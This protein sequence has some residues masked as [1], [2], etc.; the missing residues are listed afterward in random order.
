MKVCFLNFEGVPTI[1]RAIDRMTGGLNTILYNLA[2][3]IPH[4]PGGHEVSV[5]CRDDGS[6]SFA[7]RGVEMIAVPAGLRKPLSRK[8]AEAVL[9]EFT[10]GLPRVIKALR[11]DVIHTS[12][13]EA[14][15]AMAILRRDGLTT[16][17]VHT[18][19]ATLAVRRVVVE[20]M[21]PEEALSDT[22]GQRELTCVSCCDKVI[23]LCTQD[24]DEL[25]SV[26]GIPKEKIAVVPPGIDTEIFKLPEKKTG[27]RQKMII[28]SGRMSASKD[29]PFLLRSFR[30]VLDSSPD[31]NLVIVGGNS[32]ER[33]DLGLPALA[34]RLGIADRVSFIDGLPQWELAGMFQ[35]AR[36]FAGTSLHETFGLLVHEAKA[37]GTPF[38][39]RANSGYLSTSR[40]G[41]GGY[42]ADNLSEVGMAYWL[43][44]VLD[45]PEWAWSSLSSQAHKDAQRYDWEVS[46]AGCIEVYRGL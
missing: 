36:V 41:V 5:M 24:R 37:C 31:T 27:S 29:F 43:R 8:E 3:R 21:S 19:Y 34:G 26:F 6:T 18:N 23:A 28:G 11:P 22:I 45:S 2:T 9:Q 30:I 25:A 33:N 16:P 32:V 13:S 44:Y 14:G 46:C 1:E 42:F 17:W 39:A 4:L 40:N 10:S 7:G 35:K 15:L 20:G 38:V 12:G